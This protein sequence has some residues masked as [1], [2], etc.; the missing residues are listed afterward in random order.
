MPN[1]DD[2]QLKSRL[3][4]FRPI[5][6]SPLPHIG[7]HNRVDRRWL[8]L[9][10]LAAVLVIGVLALKSRPTIV[11]GT[12]T[13]KRPASPQLTIGSANTLLANSP[14]YREALDQLSFQPA[15]KPPLHATYSALDQLGKE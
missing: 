1:L 3:T 10:A 6:P 5:A 8:A 15:T 9:S 2:E 7:Q 12:N 13:A 11:L 4:Q 14:S